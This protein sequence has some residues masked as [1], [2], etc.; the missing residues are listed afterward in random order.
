MHD[1]VFDT[2]PLIHLHE[3][4]QLKIITSVFASIQIP[5]QVV[6]E[7]TNPPIL[8]FIQLH[9]ENINIHP[10]SEPDLF[11]TKDAFS[12]FRLH[13][14]DLAV[15]ML[16]KIHIEAVAVT[17]DLAL[18]KAIESSGRT[19]VGTIGFPPHCATYSKFQTGML[20]HA[21]CYGYI[22]TMIFHL[23]YLRISIHAN[24]KPA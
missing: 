2:G 22:A 6:R 13:L 5:E 8:S 23:E 10:I 3:I 1:A 21:C 16:L 11:A 15:L 4:D 18:R 7:I 12:N 17:D 24:L 9:S 19:V 20:F 14:A